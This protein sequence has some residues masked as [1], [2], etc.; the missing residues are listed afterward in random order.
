MRDSHSGLIGLIVLLDNWDEPDTFKPERWLDEAN[1]HNSAW[2]PFSKGERKTFALPEM[3][4]DSA[5]GPKNCVGLELAL[6]EQRMILAAAVS[7]LL[8]FY[9]TK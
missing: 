2:Q 9:E 5:V 7:S 6:M 1:K 3:P 8:V 4:A